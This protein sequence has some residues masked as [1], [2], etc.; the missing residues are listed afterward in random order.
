[1]KWI[2]LT[3]ML[4][5]ASNQAG[6]TLLEY[7]FDLTTIDFFNSP[8][9]NLITDRSDM[10]MLVDTN[11]QSITSISYKTKF[12]EI[13]YQG[14]SKIN[15]ELWWEI[16]ENNGYFGI[17]SRIQGAMPDG[18][19]IFMYLEAPMPYNPNPS[20]FLLDGVDDQGFG[21]PNHG[22]YWRDGNLVEV[23]EPAFLSLL[24]L[25]LATIGVRRR[26]R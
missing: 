9:D 8:D 10:I 13:D 1:M 19:E 26:L 14:S 25:G 22:G 4:L 7:T 3:M 24:L 5:L 12:F 18:G 15:A 20:Y 17:T 2:M 16:D 21:F 6:A 23:P 11:S